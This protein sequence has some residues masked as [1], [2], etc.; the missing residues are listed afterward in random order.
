MG[1]P[2]RDRRLLEPAPDE[3]GHGP[4][5]VGEVSNV[6]DDHS[7]NHFLTPV[8]RFAATEEDEAPFRLVWNELSQ[9]TV[10]EASAIG[11]RCDPMTRNSPHLRR[12]CGT[13]GR[14]PM[15]LKASPSTQGLWR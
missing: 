2:A 7:D 4:A 10:D 1:L 3:L 11:P 9:R 8:G 6:N 5:F 14:P 15:P 13:A 12:P